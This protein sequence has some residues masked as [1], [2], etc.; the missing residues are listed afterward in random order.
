MRGEVD[1]SAGAAG[2]APAKLAARLVD[3]RETAGQPENDQRSE[4]ICF[5]I[6]GALNLVPEVFVV[7]LRRHPADE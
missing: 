2:E 5:E 6:K 3:E 4:G 7:L 1:P